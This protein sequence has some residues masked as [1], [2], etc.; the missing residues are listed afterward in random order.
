MPEGENV[1]ALPFNLVVDEVLNSAQEE[2]TDARCSSAFV[3]GPNAR[4][5][6]E[7]RDC[8]AKV[9]TDGAWSPLTV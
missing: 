5:F 7:K 3:F 1:Q 8:F 2:A 9:G 6:G 4:L